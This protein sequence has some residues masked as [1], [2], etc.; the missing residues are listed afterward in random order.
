MAHDRGP[1]RVM[2]RLRFRLEK[3]EREA[4]GEMVV[5]P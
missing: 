5:I 1:G 3:L 4:E 2:G